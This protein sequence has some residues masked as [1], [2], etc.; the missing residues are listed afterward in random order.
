M[1]VGAVP[2]HL[3]DAHYPG[4]ARLGHGKGYVYPHDEP[5]AWVE[6]QYRPPHL[7]GRSYWEPW[8]E[9]K[10]RRQ[11]AR[12]LPVSQLPLRAGSEIADRA[13]DKA[14]GRIV[15]LRIA[16]RVAGSAMAAKEAELRQQLGLAETAEPDG[17][18][19]GHDHEGRRGEQRDRGRQFDR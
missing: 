3:R 7:E 16:V 9:R 11:L 14:A 12:Y 19:H 18:T 13:R 4:A 2:K 8:V 15:D 6:Q 17:L 10:A 5:G 1:A